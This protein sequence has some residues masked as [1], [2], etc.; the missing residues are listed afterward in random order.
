VAAEAGRYLRRHTSP[1]DTVYVWRSFYID[2]Y[3][4]A[5][6]DPASRYFFWPHLL[7]QP[8]PP[9]AGALFR[10]DFGRRPPAYILVGDSQIYPDVSWPALDDFLAT[11]CVPDGEVAGLRV[12]RRIR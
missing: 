4:Y 8:Q 1:R 3:F 10:E 7:R 12:Y 6:R 5:E 9:G 2:I 11:R